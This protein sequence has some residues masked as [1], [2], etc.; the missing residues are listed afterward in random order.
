MQPS[1][2]TNVNVEVSPRP[3]RLANQNKKRTTTIY[4]APRNSNIPHVKYARQLSSWGLLLPSLRCP[5]PAQVVPHLLWAS[6]E[7]RA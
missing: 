7:Q 4:P 5:F 6:E 2:T 1:F 3:S